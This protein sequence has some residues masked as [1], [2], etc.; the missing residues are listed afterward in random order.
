MPRSRKEELLERIDEDL[1][2]NKKKIRETILNSVMTEAE[3][4]ESV[5]RYL[6][7]I[8]LLLKTKQ[9]ILDNF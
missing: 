8:N 5:N 3:K 9:I 4:D 2:L 1:R 7:Q 6:D